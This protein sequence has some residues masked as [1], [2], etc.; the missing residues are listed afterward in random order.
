MIS[1]RPISVRFD[2][3]ETNKKETSTE[4]H[5]KEYNV[6]KEAYNVSKEAYNMSKE[7]YQKPY[8]IFNRSITRQCVVSL[9]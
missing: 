6:S 2:D 5:N 3:K 8:F 9:L 1:N 7:T 4:T